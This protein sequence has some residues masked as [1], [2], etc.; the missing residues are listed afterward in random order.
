MTDDKQKRLK[1]RTLAAQA[2]GADDPTTKAVVPPLHVSTTYIR[3]PDNQ[4]RTGYMYGRPD[5]ATIRQ[6]EAVIAALEQAPQAMLSGSGMAAATSVILALEKPSHIVASQIMYWAFRHWLTEAS[7]FGHRIEF[8]DT[9]DINAVRAA[10]RPGETALVYVETPGNPLWTITDIAAVA[11]VA[12][13]AGARL[14]VDSTVATPIFT[15]PI[16]LGADVVMHSATKYLNGHSDVIAG[17]LATA[18]EDEF[19][20]RIQNVRAQHGAILGPFEAWLLLRGLRT[21][22]MRVRT[23]TESAALLASW[24]MRHP[25]VSHVLYP[26]LQHH[27]GHAVAAKQM[28]GGYGAMLSIRVA[29]GEQAAI[30]TA[31]RVEVWKRATSLGGVESLI[32]HRASVEGPNTPC[33]PDLLRLSVGLEDPEDLYADLDRALHASN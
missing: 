19:W 8:V 3:D 10:V 25:A 1:A 28:H 26:G 31:A 4:Y 11:D 33:P 21:L 32:E 24:L 15:R 29:T 6:A 23:Q 9:S 2:L 30:S 7:R 22:D 18:R 20:R 5:N 17:A 12:H 14:C 13:K 16:S 27:P